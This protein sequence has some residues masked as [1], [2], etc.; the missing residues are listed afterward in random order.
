MKKLKF[1]TVI[2]APAQKVYEYM[3]GLKDISTYQSWTKAFNPTSSFEGDW[4]IGSKILF[5]G[6]DENGNKGGMVSEVV[7]HQPAQLVSVRH[8]GYL[9]GDQEI[10]TGEE[11]EKWAGGHETYIFDEKDG[12]TTLTV[13]MD[14]VEEYEQYFQDNYP[15]ALEILKKDCEH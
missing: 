2:N 8:Y 6:M 4:S 12:K 13:E 10:T 15:K 3:L 5:V 14:S 1:Q 9:Q 7:E 11:V